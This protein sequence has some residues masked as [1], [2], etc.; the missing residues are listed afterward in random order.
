MNS[1]AGV[2]DANKLLW[3]GMTSQPETCQPETL[4]GGQGGGQAVL[5]WCRVTASHCQE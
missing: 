3:L 1:L 4:S 2:F 5:G